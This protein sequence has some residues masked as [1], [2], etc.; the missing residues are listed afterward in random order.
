MPLSFPRFPDTIA[1]A[2]LVAEGG[3]RM[4]APHPPE[5]R[6]RAVELARL[7][8][9]PSREIARDR[10]LRVVP[11]ELAGPGPTPTPAPGRF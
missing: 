6:W 8:E 10:D 1:E 9:K 11:A 4:P 2:S 5:F 3:V 7:R